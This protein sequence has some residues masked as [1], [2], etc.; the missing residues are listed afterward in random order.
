MKK[1]LISMLALLAIATTAGAQ[2]KIN[3][4]EYV[5]LGL[6]SGLLWATCNVGATNPEEYGDYF[7]WGETEP[8]EEYTWKTYKFGT[9]KAL[10]KYTGSDGLTVLEAADDAAAVNWKGGW[11][12]PTE[13][14]F[15][16][17]LNKTTN[18]WVTQGGV[19]G[20]LFTAENG[21]S[22]FLPA[23][24]YR[25]GGS[26]K[27]VDSDGYCWS[28][29][30]NKFNPAYAYYL[31]FSSD[32]AYCNY[33][34]RYYG[35]CVRPVIGQDDIPTG[36]E[37]N[38]TNFPDKNFRSFV[39]GATIDKD[40]NGYLSTEEIAAV[41]TIDVNN[42]SIADLTGIEYFT[43]L[44][45]LYCQ[46]N[47]LKSL[48][49]SKNTKLKGLYSYY[50]ELT[51]L[52]VS[53][54]INLTSFTCYRNQI[55]GDKMQALVESLPKVASGN[56]SVFKLDDEKEKNV[57][58]KSQVA[59]AKSKGW[60]V[61]ACKQID[62]YNYEWSEY[63]G[64][65]EATEKVLAVTFTKATTP[66]SELS[67]QDKNV[68]A[69]VTKLAEKEKLSGYSVVNDARRGTVT[70][71]NGT[72]ILFV[73][74]T[75]KETITVP[76]GVTS[77]DNINVELTKNLRQVLGSTIAT[78]LA[79]Y[80]AIQI[81]FDINNTPTSIDNS[82]LTNDNLNGDWYS[83]D[84]KRLSGEPTQKGVYIVNGRKVVK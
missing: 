26:L 48:D 59:L 56:F 73:V 79:S 74:D 84:G 45:Q 15:E 2:N 47:P 49:V 75:N 35:Q 50:N 38:A 27:C 11:R 63:E 31:N 65:E 53:E 37:I 3:G 13:A 64:S 61:W 20:R 83:I 58:T 19:K 42:Q 29:S 76:S 10:T 67:A 28:S 30:L 25:D 33:G 72:K 54:N 32:N 71:K 62:A 21:N 78:P 4:H 5:D 39:S 14:D 9:E 60:K 82:Q 57:I 12:M 51:E 69:A 8:K 1:I 41:K 80:D 46:G 81:K 34:D 66:V 17:L 77:A 7:A 68:L 36:I 44:E 40:G 18:K 70:L 24:G 52:D 6:P 55:K 43:A 23:S 22:I 16:E